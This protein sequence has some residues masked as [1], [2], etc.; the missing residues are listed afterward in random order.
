MVEYWTIACVTMVKWKVGRK[1]KEFGTKK[2]KIESDKMR[3]RKC[4]K[5]KYREMCK[6]IGLRMTDREMVEQGTTECG[7]MGGERMGPGT[8]G[9]RT[10]ERWVTDISMMD[11][12]TVECGTMVR[13]RGMMGRR[14]LERETTE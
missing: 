12:G 8:M 11:S 1:T 9:L 6:L 3:E 2:G 7:R 13:D 10:F 4:V 5:V 14:A